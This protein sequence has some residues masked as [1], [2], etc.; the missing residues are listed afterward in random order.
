[1]QGM[2]GTKDTSQTTGQFPIESLNRNVVDSKNRMADFESFGAKIP[3]SNTATNQLK[4]PS[5]GDIKSRAGD[6]ANSMKESNAL[7]IGSGAAL[8]TVGIVGAVVLAPIT[9]AGGILGIS[10]KVIAKLMDKDVPEKAM[11]ASLV[12]GGLAIAGVQ[13]MHEGFEGLKDK[14]KATEPKNESPTGLT[15]KEPMQKA[16]KKVKT[17]VQ[18]KKSENIEEKTP[19]ESKM[20]QL[21]EKIEKK[22]ELLKE[23]EQLIKNKGTLKGENEIRKN[24]SS[25]NE[26]AAKKL[27]ADN[28]IR[29]LSSELRK[30]GISDEAPRLTLNDVKNNKG[31]GEEK[32]ELLESMI[33]NQEEKIMELSYKLDIA[34]DRL[35]TYN[36]TITAI[37]DSVKFD[38]ETF[39]TDEFK[40]ILDKYPLTEDKSEITKITSEE[41]QAKQLELKD[42]FEEKEKFINLKGL[43]LEQK[44]P[45]LREKFLNDM[46]S[47]PNETYRSFYEDFKRIDEGRQALENKPET[48][49]ASSLASLKEYKTSVEEEIKNKNEEIQEIQDKFKEDAN[50][51][52]DSLNENDK[53][54]IEE[55]TLKAKF[56]DPNQVYIRHGE[57]Y[58][59]Q[60]ENENTLI[61][62]T[63]SELKKLI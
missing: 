9:V 26:M 8:T 54:A 33:Y 49:G 37:E 12:F 22:K 34:E 35:L 15:K 45:E 46:A 42:K 55:T 4:F 2:G 29:K 6:A 38:V 41:D 17:K 48:P 60:A 57:I 5:W 56:L 21:N 63:Q 23:E 44:T 62:W 13:L 61:N 19:V 59:N 1:M 53:S 11:I 14:Q 43:Y 16:E 27:E 10:A 51:I 31:T 36:K 18:E 3:D 25:L 50:T 28:E 7:L 47:S 20:A 52:L 32:M 58:P 24:T 30:L 40:K 39:T